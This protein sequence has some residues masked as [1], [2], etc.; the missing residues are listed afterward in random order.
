[1]KILGIDY[2]RSKIGLATAETATGL[3]EPMAVVPRANIKKQIS[4]IVCEN[5]IEKIVVG[6]PGGRL[7][8]EI[9][10]FGRALE[11]ETGLPIE[12][13]D[14][15]LTSLDARKLLLKV[16]KK[17]KFRQEWEDAYAA[18]IMLESYL[19]HLC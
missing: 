4:R 10:K 15:T 2:G 14:E 1:M 9:K 8:A 3:A 19:S 17:R 5:S 7:D 12:Y 16:Q 18:A 11:Q 6:L 13:F